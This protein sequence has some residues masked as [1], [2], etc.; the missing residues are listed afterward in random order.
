MEKEIC[1]DELHFKCAGVCNEAVIFGARPAMWLGY[2]ENRVRSK[3]SLQNAF[4]ISF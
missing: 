1:E 2:K 3:V 4:R